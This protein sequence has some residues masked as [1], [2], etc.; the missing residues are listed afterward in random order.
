VQTPSHDYTCRFYCTKEAFGLAMANATMDIDYRHFKETSEYRKA[1]DGISPRYK[2]ASEYHKTLLSIWSATLSLG[3]AGS[4]YGPWSKDNPDGYGKKTKK[5]KRGRFSAFGDV[6]EDG[7]GLYADDLYG[8][9]QDEEERY[10]RTPGAAAITTAAEWSKMV[11]D[12]GIADD[13]TPASERGAKRIYDTVKD[14]PVRE[15]ADELTTSEFQLVTDFVIRNHEDYP[16]EVMD[17]ARMDTS[18]A[19]PR[20]RRVTRSPRRGGRAK[21]RA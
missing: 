13:Y 8:P 7:Y 5:S 16:L 11:D 4:F 20:D 19:K 12:R 10:Y 2:R 1:A 14:L 6:E 18:P 21:V 9:A 17:L 15:W 3:T